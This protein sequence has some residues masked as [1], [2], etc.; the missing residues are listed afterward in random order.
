MTRG[1]RIFYFAWIAYLARQTGHSILFIIGLALLYAVA[2]WGVSLII[3]GV[4]R[5][6]RERSKEH[7]QDRE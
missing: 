1:E 2:A 5:T 4:A 7:E 3:D 6:F